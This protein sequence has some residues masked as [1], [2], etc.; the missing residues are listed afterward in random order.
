M[1]IIFIMI[2]LKNEN[3][4]I[5]SYMYFDFYIE[6]YNFLYLLITKYCQ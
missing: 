3:Y 6:V 4:K 1:K 2:T 5:K